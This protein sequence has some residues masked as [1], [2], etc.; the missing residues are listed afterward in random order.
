MSV[1]F[2]IKCYLSLDIVT[3]FFMPLYQIMIAISETYTAYRSREHRIKKKIEQNS[4]SSKKCCQFLRWIKLNRTKSEFCNYMFCDWKERVELWWSTCDVAH[5]FDSCQSHVLSRHRP[6][7]GN[8]DDPTDLI[9]WTDSMTTDNT[10]TEGTQGTQGTPLYSDKQGPQLTA[11][12]FLLT[13]T[14]D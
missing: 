6:G 11:P 10:G 3:N 8:L 12:N 4:H 2:P 7:A 5:N 14:N 9:Q 1:L 13:Q